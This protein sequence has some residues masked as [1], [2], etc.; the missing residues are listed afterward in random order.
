MDNNGKPL[1]EAERE[2]EG[3]SS[4]DWLLL[5]ERSQAVVPMDTNV[6]MQR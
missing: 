6:T 5:K 3:S 2:E 1:A 4:L